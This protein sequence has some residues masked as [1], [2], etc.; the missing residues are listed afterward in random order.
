MTGAKFRL[1]YKG[2]GKVLK[3]PE[4]AAHVNGVAEDLRAK[5]GDDA[6]MTAYTSDRQAASVRVP[7]HLQARNGS[8]TRA[9]AQ[10]GLEVRS[11]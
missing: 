8:L 2:V 1:N 7:A 3:S 4:M 9:A 10:L 5:I 11:R 6:E